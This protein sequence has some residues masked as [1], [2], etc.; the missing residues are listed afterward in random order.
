MD[1]PS[2]SPASIRENLR[3]LRTDS[4]AA[5]EWRAVSKCFGG[6]SPQTAPALDNF[7]LAVRAGEFLTLLG[8]SGCGKTTALRLLSGLDVPDTGQVFLAG[9]DVT[10]LPPHRREVNQVFQ[11]Y[12]LF[13][14][15][16]VADNIAFGLR[17][18]RL[19][20][21]DIRA[22]TARAV[23]LLAL[24]GLLDRRPAALSGGQRQRVALARALV[25][26]P[27]VLL[28][29]EPLSALDA[30]LRAQVRGELRALQRQLGL[31]FVFVTHDQE[32]ALTL[33]D[34]VAV[35]HAGHLEQI[36]TPEEIYRHPRNRFVAGFIGEANLL[37][38]SPIRLEDGLLLCH[39]HRLNG[40]MQVLRAR[41]PDDLPGVL[42][43]KPV[44]LLIR[45]ERVRLRAE[46]LAPDTTG[47]VIPVRVTERIFQG[48]AILLTLEFADAASR[49]E[50]ASFRL[51]ASVSPEQPVSAA[52]IGSVLSA[53]IAP[54]DI[55]VLP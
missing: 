41:P 2:A 52:P 49:T 21:A 37:D 3:N 27:R 35:M 28:L 33:S 46:A 30:R 29:D 32:E 5:A 39:L 9:Q 24:G 19:P 25:C 55:T 38:A 31:T 18:K 50:P 45:P 51:C 48:A 16:N 10:A 26:E 20:A 42:D 15:L 8:P 54:E 43:G 7:H 47:N 4:V 17:M 22:R 13:P 12:A 34:R 23:E 11:S 40:P 14:H 6:H 36:G 44:Q 53:G 1:I